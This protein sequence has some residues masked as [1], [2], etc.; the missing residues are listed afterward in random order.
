M[1]DYVREGSTHS[2]DTLNET[3]I[4]LE[5]CEIMW[6][7]DLLLAGTYYMKLEYEVCEIMWGNDLLIAGTFY[8]K[9][10]YEVCE[11]MWGKDLLIAGTH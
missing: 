3:G 10:E 1:W 5:V 11:I 8:M 6:G 9:L 4:R 2:R 7:N